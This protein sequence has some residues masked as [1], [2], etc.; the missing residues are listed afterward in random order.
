MHQR[1]RLNERGVALLWLQPTN[2]DGEECRGRDADLLARRLTAD[3]LVESLKVHA[4]IDATDAGGVAA[5]RHD[6]P[7]DRVTHGNEVINTRRD[8]LKQLA[9]FS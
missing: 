4:V 2:C 6:L 8:L 1:P 5:L 3:H 7:H 9:V